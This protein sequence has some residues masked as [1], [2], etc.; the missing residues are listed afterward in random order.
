MDELIETH[1]RCIFAYITAPC[2]AA[3]LTFSC[4]VIFHIILPFW[5]IFTICMLGPLASAIMRIRIWWK[6]EILFSPEELDSR[7]VNT[8]FSA[9]IPELLFVVLAFGFLLAE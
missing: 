1:N 6:K 8:F 3:L 7:I 5:L 9:I 4:V 2:S